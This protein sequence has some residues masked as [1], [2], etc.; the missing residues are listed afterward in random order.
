MRQ[1]HTVVLYTYEYVHG[2]PDGVAVRD[3][4]TVIPRHE[5][6][7]YPANVGSGNSYAAFANLFR[8]KL[9]L[10]HGGWWVDTDV[11]CIRPFSTVSHVFASEPGRNALIHN[12][13][14]RTDIG[15]PVMAEMYDRAREIDPTTLTWGRTGGSMLTRVLD[16]FPAYQKFIVPAHV[17]CPTHWNKI[18]STVQAG[19]PLILHPETRGVHLFNEMWKR[20][21]L[22]IDADWPIY[23]TLKQRSTQ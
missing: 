17:F 22:D 9:L 12:G 20:G 13:I 16:Q 19:G 4:A 15:C 1:G 7:T 11:Y 6:F 2:I 5:L 23:K 3:A 8:Y 10:E 18:V 21:G 14:I